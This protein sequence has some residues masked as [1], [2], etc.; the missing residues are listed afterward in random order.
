[1]AEEVLTGILHTTDYSTFTVLTESG[2]W[3][4]SFTGAK[5]AGYALP[6][7]TVTWNPTTRSCQLVK[8]TK[9]W[10]IVG[11]LELTSKTK[12]GMSSRGVPQ[13]LFTP[14]NKKYPFMVVGCSERNATTNFLA[15]V[16][17]DS[18]SNTGLPRG[19]LRKLLGPCGHASAERQMLLLNYNPFKP[20]KTHEFQ[21]EPTVDWND[22]ETC[23]SLTF[24]IDPDGCRDIDDVLSIE[25]GEYWWDLWITI[26][27]VA[28][29]VLPGSRLDEFAALQVATAYDNGGAV[30]PMLPHTYS[31]GFCSLLPGMRRPGLSCIVRIWKDRMTEI[32]S[33]RWCKSIVINAQQFTYDGFQTGAATAGIPTRILAEFAKGVLGHATNDPH[34]WIEACMLK[35]NLEAAKVLRKAGSGVLRKHDQ[36]DLEML[37]RYAMLGGDTLAVLANKSAQY[38]PANDTE[39]IHYGLKANIYCHASSPI[40]RYADLVNQRVLKAALIGQSLDVHPNIGWMNERQ[41]DLKRYE[42]DLFLLDQITANAVGKITALV[43]DVQPFVLESHPMKKVKL[44]IPEWKRL[45]TWKTSALDSEIVGAGVKIKLS[46]FANPAVRFW[47]QK[48]IFHYDG[49]ADD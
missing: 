42:R 20:L 32:H 28:E 46:Y 22:R 15:V 18:W 44:W 2:T 16:D 29:V 6:G 49:V 23:P 24:N 10:P 48:V 39:P 17:F 3:L 37:G 19:T 8:R 31:E 26:A 7:D 41:T 35:Y 33:V 1:M 11:V 25:E 27:D 5:Y 43:L 9:H 36:P 34:K 14:C 13:Y 45:L 30:Q 4:N 38:C 21:D 47:K 12:Y 40:R